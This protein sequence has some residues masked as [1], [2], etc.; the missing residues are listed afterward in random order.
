MSKRVYPKTPRAKPAE[1]P[2]EFESFRYPELDR[3]LK[4][5]L[6]RQHRMLGRHG[7]TLHAATKTREFKK[8][9]KRVWGLVGEWPQSALRAIHYYTLFLNEVDGYMHHY[10][11]QG[12]ACMWIAL[13][14]EYDTNIPGTDMVDHL[15]GSVPNPD[16]CCEYLIQAEREVAETLGYNFSR[17]MPIEFAN[18]LV[19]MVSD[20]PAHMRA[21]M[22]T[23]KR[24]SCR[25]RF[26]MVPP[27]F[28][29][30]AVVA[31]VVPSAV[32][33]LKKLVPGCDMDYIL[34]HV[35]LANE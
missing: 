19:C 12:Y 27:S 23:L 6:D 32:E 31:A 5:L 4:G 11:W 21:V 20:G 34:P 30:A 26:V 25:S 29:A 2:L 13:K 1:T 28:L 24:C 35:R 8:W 3:Q 9:T 7:S 33:D 17:P 10:K 15:F 22:K 16:E 14:M 18:V